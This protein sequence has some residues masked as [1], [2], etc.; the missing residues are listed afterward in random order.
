M[1]SFCQRQ[2]ALAALPLDAPTGSRTC[3]ITNRYT[4]QQTRKDTSVE[5]VPPQT[6]QHQQHEQFARIEATLSSLNETSATLA[7]TLI[8]L[9]SDK[10]YVFHFI[11]FYNIY[12]G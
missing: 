9:S 12:T 8:Q 2:R 11:S 5:P 7:T 6:L 4:Q 10:K 3:A 1:V